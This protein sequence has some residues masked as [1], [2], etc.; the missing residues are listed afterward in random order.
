MNLKSTM[1]SPEEFKLIQENEQVVVAN[2]SIIKTY[3]PLS[4][5]SESLTTINR[6]QILN[7]KHKNGSEIILSL[8][9]TMKKIDVRRKGGKWQGWQPAQKDF[10]KELLADYCSENI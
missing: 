1:I 3:G 10:E 5:K 4:I 9:C 8:E 6:R 2:N 7:A